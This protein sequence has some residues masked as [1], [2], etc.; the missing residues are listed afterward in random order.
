M[1][2]GSHQTLILSVK[3]PSQS[4][5]LAGPRLC[6]QFRTYDSANSLCFPFKFRVFRRPP[7]R[8]HR[9]PRSTI[10]QQTK[11]KF[12]LETLHNVWKQS[13]SSILSNCSCIEARHS[14]TP[15][16]RP[17][18]KT[19]EL[20]APIK[21]G[22]HVQT[23]VPPNFSNRKLLHRKPGPKLHKILGKCH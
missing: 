9:E 12:S 17:I 6:Y 15:M 18:Q 3:F 19:I 8:V 21:C 14:R 20:P 22:C 4:G 5:H 1:T 16:Q 11:S 2:R 7:T 13:T 23:L 10:R